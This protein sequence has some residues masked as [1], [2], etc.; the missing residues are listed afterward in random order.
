MKAKDF[1]ESEAYDSED[2]EGSPSQLYLDAV[3]LR[4]RFAN[5]ADALR[6]LTIRLDDLAKNA[7]L[8]VADFLTQAESSSDFKEEYLDALM[9][10]RQ[11]H[12]LK[13]AI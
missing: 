13:S 11:I 2:T 1:K 8:S 10:A 12:R 7:G 3:R 9:L 6:S 5:N 4:P